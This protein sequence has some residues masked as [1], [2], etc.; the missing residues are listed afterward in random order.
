MG[1]EPTTSRVIGRG[2]NQLRYS[3][4]FPGGASNFCRNAQDVHRSVANHGWVLAVSYLCGLLFKLDY[5]SG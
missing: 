2:S 3:D 1:L 5:R 4:S